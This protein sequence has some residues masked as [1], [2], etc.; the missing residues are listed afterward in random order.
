M[1]KTS[2]KKK[3]LAAIAVLSFLS[4][5]MAIAQPKSQE[6]CVAAAEN[7][8]DTWYMPNWGCDA[9]YRECRKTWY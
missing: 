9:L 4:A 1:E 2:I 6:E 8:Y 5:G 7:C 3:A